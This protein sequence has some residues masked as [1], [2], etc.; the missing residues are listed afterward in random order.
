MAIITA[1]N[2]FRFFRAVYAD[3]DQ[4]RQNK[5]RIQKDALL[6][7]R[8]R[9]LQPLEWLASQW[10]RDRE[11]PVVFIVGTP[12]SGTTLFYQLIARHLDVAYP[13]NFVARYWLAPVL[14]M[15]RFQRS[16]S[17]SQA[18]IPL[19]SDFGGTTGPFSPHEFSWFWEFY[20]WFREVDDLS[21]DEL[22]RIDWAAIRR[23]LEGLSGYVGRP[24]VLK[25]LN[26]VVYNIH[27]FAEEFPTAKFLSIRRDPRFVVQS[28]LE[29]RKERY[30]D[31]SLWWTIRPRDYQSWLHR[32]AIEQVCHQVDD[33]R[34]AIGQ[35]LTS[36][37]ADRKLELTY[38]DLIADP[39]AQLSRVAD[40]IGNVPFIHVEAL[41][42][43]VL[44]NGNI[45]R[46]DSTDFDTIL[47]KTPHAAGEL[48]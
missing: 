8:N 40:L 20:T 5:R 1:M 7:A 27:R 11:R 12:R 25:S 13:N 19:Q 4:R 15:W 39:Y 36:L 10:Y 14:G 2:A 9:A 17:S 47:E 31:E 34:R 43:L 48:G 23:E 3:N 35:G 18:D 37:P 29:S 21:E 24:L 41:R 6:Y 32:P 45:R 42:A 33:I 16:Y 46:M 44:K 26:Y 38:E 30:G 28:I 22:D